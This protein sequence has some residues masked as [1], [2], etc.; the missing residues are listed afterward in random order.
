MSEYWILRDNEDEFQ[1][2]VH[3]HPRDLVNE[4]QN[5]GKDFDLIERDDGC[6][7]LVTGALSPGLLVLGHYER[8]SQEEWETYHTFEN[9]PEES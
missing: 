1:R 5:Q 6:C 4:L 7:I 2:L 8:V 3:V 9:F